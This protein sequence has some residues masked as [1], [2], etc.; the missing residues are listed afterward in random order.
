M[1]YTYRLT[2]QHT[3][4]GLIAACAGASPANR[5]LIPVEGPH[6]TLNAPSADDALPD[7]VAGFQIASRDGENIQGDSDDPSGYPS[8]A[9]L[10]ARTAESV[11]GRWDQ[12]HDLALD[13]IF[14]GDVEEPEFIRAAA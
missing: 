10:D 5:T 7:G 11:I 3:P 13:V 9:I 1:T 8:Y 6:P 12:S 2:G 14:H 4:R